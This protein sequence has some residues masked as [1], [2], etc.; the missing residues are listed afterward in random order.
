MKSKNKCQLHKIAIYTRVSTEEQAE[1]PEGSIKNQELRLREYIQLKNQMEP[2]GEV[3]GVYSDPGISAKNMKRP[4]FQ[5]M[6]TAIKNKEVTLVLVTELSRFSRS[7]K[8]FAMLQEFLETN[9][10]K[11]MSLRE[12]FDTSGAAGSMVLNLMASIAEFE[13]RQ[14]AERISHSFLARAKRGLYNGGSLP[15]GYESDPDRPGYLKIVES[16]AELVRLIFKT[17]LKEK[18]LA[19][20]AKF[21]NKEEV[22]LPQ[23]MRNGG[24][25][26]NDSV[27]FETVYR[28]LKNKAYIGIKVYSNKSGDMEEAKAVWPA[29]I[30]EALFNRVQEILKNNCSKRKTHSN[31]YPFTLSGLIKCSV[32]G[33]N[34]AG[35]SATGG[36]GKRVPYYEHTTTRKIEASLNYKLIDHKPRR[37]PALIIEDL[38]WLEVKR[39]LLDQKFSEMLLSLAKNR[40]KQ[41]DQ[42]T[43]LD[44]VL[45]KKIQTEKQIQVLAERISDLPE[46]LDP[47]PLYQ[48][49]ADLQKGL[50]KLQSD[51]QAQEFSKATS[52]SVIQNDDFASFKEKLKKHTDLAENNPAIRSAIIKIIVHKIEIKPN[53]FDI[54][55]NFGENHFNEALGHTPSASIFVSV[56]L[57]TKMPSVEL[58]A[59]GANFVSKVFKGRYA[60]G[61]NESLVGSGSLTNGG[62]SRNRTDTG[63]LPQDFESSKSTNFIIEPPTIYRH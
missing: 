49:L 25:I 1:N 24:S 61:K 55:F 51:L 39:F 42:N 6:L 3:V 5:K 29:I 13:R 26:R 17:F 44:K 36:N 15:L 32:C 9:N 27:R 7:T 54:H 33:E 45:K 59:E 47:K 63:L 41:N 4:S 21:L 14:T 57:K 50:I 11:F 31:K 56:D 43:E 48:K 58:S 18:T 46:G 52:D 34:M 22:R 10:C 16:E 40:Y 53:G 12:N 37:I 60:V 20:A 2:F 30:D 38:V 62:S 19:A 23:R 8:D 35:A 28:V